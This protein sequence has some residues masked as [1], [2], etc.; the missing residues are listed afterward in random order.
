MIDIECRTVKGHVPSKA[1]GLDV[2]CSLEKGLICSSRK[3][4]KQCP[5]FEIRVKCRCD[6]ESAT[7]TPVTI[8]PGPCDPSV[9]HIEHPTNCHLF[10]HCAPSTNGGYEL[11]E[12]SCGEHM[13]FNPESMICDWLDEV[14]RIKPKCGGKYN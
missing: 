2:E 5:D 11:V 12:K 7:E 1:T 9:P 4:E 14:I 6:K 13:F 8:A 3:G 10:Y